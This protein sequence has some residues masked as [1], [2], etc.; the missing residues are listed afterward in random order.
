MLIKHCKL[1]SKGIAKEQSCSFYSLRFYII[2]VKIP[3]YRRSTSIE[4]CLKDYNL[5]RR[6]ITAVDSTHTY[7][8]RLNPKANIVCAVIISSAPK[9]ICI[10]EQEK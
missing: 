8:S 10:P 3:V 2:N 6:T 1:A 9:V 7:V 4:R 5:K